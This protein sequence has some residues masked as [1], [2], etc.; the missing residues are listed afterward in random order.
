MA[1][2]PAKPA[3]KPMGRVKKSPQELAEYFYNQKRM[4]MVCFFSSLALLACFV[5]M[6]WKDYNRSWKEYQRAFLATDLALVQLDIE[7]K[8]RELEAREKELSKN[9]VEIDA[10]EL[11]LS[12]DGEYQGVLEWIE[13]HD[14]EWYA[15]NMD[16]KFADSN[17]K[18]A[19]SEFEIKKHDVEKAK[20]QK[21]PL[22]SKLLGEEETALAKLRTADVTLTE[23]R[24][25]FDAIDVKMTAAKAKKEAREAHRE[26]F[27]TARKKVL[28]EKE[29]LVRRLDADKPRL[30]NAIRN[31]PMLDF[32]APQEKIRQVVL[33]EV[34]EDIKFDTIIDKVDRCMTCHVAIS[35]PKWAASKEYSGKLNEEVYHFDDPVRR[36]LVEPDWEGADPILKDE[37]VAAFLNSP[38]AAAVRREHFKSSDDRQRFVKAFMAHPFPELYVT[39]GSPHPVERFGCTSCH[40]GDGRD[41]EFSRVVHVPGDE[42]EQQAWERRHHYHLRHLWDSPMLPT[43]YVYASCRKCHS[44]Q[45]DLKGSGSYGEGLKLFERA[46]CYGCHRTEGYSVLDKDLPVLPTTGE[47]DASKRSRRPGPPLTHVKDKTTEA[48]AYH[49]ILRP[50]DFRV[51]TRMPHFFGQTNARTVEVRSIGKD[52]AVLR[53]AGPAEV[54]GVIAA[55]MVKYLWGIS[56]S[57]T[58]AAPSA[59]G[60]VEKG[61]YIYESVGCIACHNVRT[62]DEVKKAR[63]DGRAPASERLEEFA[64]SLAAIGAK[65]DGAWLFQ[66]LRAPHAYY[67]DTRMPN[68]RLTD[69]EAGHLTAYLMSLKGQNPAWDE[70]MAGAPMPDLSSEPAQQLIQ[71]LMREMMS[72]RTPVTL[73]KEQ[74]AKMAAADRVRWFGDKMVQNFGCYGCHEME[75]PA[76][77]EEEQWTMLQGIGVE[78]TGA[79]PFGSKFHE[80]LDFG[81]AVFDG[82]HH[83]GVE[84]KD[85]VTGKTLHPFT[86]QPAEGEDVKAQVP[87]T[88]HDWARAKVRNPRVFDAGKMESKPPDELLR[89]P[90]FGFNDHEADLL[91]TVLLSFTDHESKG[92]MKHIKK[93]LNAREQAINR[94]QRILRE[95]NCASCHRMTAGRIQLEWKA[96]Q[97]VKRAWFDA[98]VK[99][100][101]PEEVAAE[102]SNMEDEDFTWIWAKPRPKAI[103]K[104]YV[105]APVGDPVT[106]KAP[107]E[108]LP[109]VKVP[110]EGVVGIE[111][112]EGGTI[113]AALHEA[114]RA[115]YP[116]KDDQ[117]IG[118]L[119][120]PWLRTQ[121]HKTHP[122][123][124]FDFLKQPVEIRPNLWRPKALEG[125]Y[126][127]Q[128][129]I[130]VR[131]GDFKLTDE[132]AGALVKYFAAVDRTGEFESA[133]QKSP[134]AYAARLPKIRRFYADVNNDCIKCHFLAGTP[135]AD[136]ENL[137]KWAPDLLSV[138]GRLRPTWLHSWME[139]PPAIYPGTIMLQYPWNEAMAPITDGPDLVETMVSTMLNIR[140]VHAELKPPKP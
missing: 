140:R 10:E 66:W 9:Q 121:G 27:K 58:P 6:V 127:D 87:E 40:E 110:E 84:V 47:R 20:E 39:S 74:I 120:P 112:G 86:L 26:A 37:T 53:K 119:V 107:A 93:D 89:M 81:G 88:R 113:V 118:L 41:T 19:R 68:L 60:S 54:E 49:W 72:K 136:L 73:A 44:T 79:Q 14:G 114:K 116:G 64:P 57:R 122:E 43:K 70:R 32:F 62:N 63:A 139:L 36:K 28:A 23:A 134:E 96:G 55:A 101:T 22:V 108:A 61:K 17:Q 50:R 21:S 52:D 78:L 1:D 24:A 97:E 77:A 94:G 99:P 76:K 135:P 117:Q 130:Q 13:G 46:G 16:F 138:E 123:W 2:T 115:V 104:G 15:K 4:H 34:K 109:A 11:L 25:A 33:A 69:E 131:M 29:T 38:E 128:V 83:F 18:A 56:Q 7:R 5:A 65:V 45:V 124:L 48:W 126:K 102:N 30:A 137:L 59:A 95:Q 82:V 105:L 103:T 100:M 42:G 35:D 12:R 90:N 91:T 31:A 71:H 132:E 133:P 111:V 75:D 92:L 51:T 67:P 85:P 129:D 106:L 3:A 8:T 80:K 125:P 98:W